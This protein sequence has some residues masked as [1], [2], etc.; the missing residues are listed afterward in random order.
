MGAQKR[1][2]E[3]KIIKEREGS[4]EN[5]VEKGESVFRVSSA[6]LHYSSNSPTPV[7]DVEAKEE[8]L[9]KRLAVVMVRDEQRLSDV[10]TGNSLVSSEGT[11]SYTL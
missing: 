6:L 4:S 5:I 2:L 11:V 3:Q 8:S 7:L 9:T 1:N 10:L